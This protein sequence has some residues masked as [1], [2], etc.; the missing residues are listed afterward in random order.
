MQPIIFLKIITMSR[1]LL[2]GV[3]SLMCRY[4]TAN[5]LRNASAFLGTNPDS[6][7][8]V[9]DLFWSLLNSNEFVLNH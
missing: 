3:E 8:V 1:Y 2:T 7:Y 6:I 9:E 5:E 4:P